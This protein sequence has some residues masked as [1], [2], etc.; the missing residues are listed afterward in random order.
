MALLNT[1][2]LLWIGR[3]VEHTEHDP[4]QIFRLKIRK[5]QSKN[6]FND[7]LPRADLSGGQSNSTLVMHCFDHIF[8]QAQAA[9]ART[10]E[11]PT[12]RCPN[13]ALNPWSLHGLK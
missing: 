8:C 13:R 5:I 11:I 12:I 3:S 1:L 9:S 6:M 7:T 10:S 2:C 4:T